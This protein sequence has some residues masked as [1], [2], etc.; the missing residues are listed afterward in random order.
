MTSGV[1]L[2][3]NSRTG[4]GYVGSSVNVEVRWNQ[5]R[6][7]LNGQRHHCKALQQA[8]NKHGSSA[9]E[10]QLLETGP[11]DQLK[12]LEQACLNRLQPEYN[13]ARTVD[14]PTEVC[15][16]KAA[17]FSS[18]R[19]RT[20][21]EREKTRKSLQSYWTP[22]RRAEHGEK[23]KARSRE[24]SEERKIQLRAANAKRWADPGQRTAQSQVAQQVNNQR[25]SKQA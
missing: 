3:R 14:R 6:V 8:W 1:Y 12:V 17:A 25:W 5:H 15:R 9:F 21:E 4:R 23:M 7:D 11:E 16:Q 19:E 10:F 22:E 20:P 13:S 18:A 24:V 2:I